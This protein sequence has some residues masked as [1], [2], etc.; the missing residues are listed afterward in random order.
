[1]L[2]LAV[3]I[4]TTVSQRSEIPEGHMNYP[5]FYNPSQISINYLD[6]RYSSENFTLV[7]YYATSSCIPLPTFRDNPSVPSSRVKKVGPLRCP[8]TSA[9]NY[10]YSLH[11]SPQELSSHLLHGGSQKSLGNPSASIHPFN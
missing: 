6:N 1:M 4:P 8:E 7:G 10:H 11:N 2:P 9:R 5:V 3:T